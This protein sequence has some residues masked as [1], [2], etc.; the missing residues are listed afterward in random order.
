MTYSGLGGLLAVADRSDAIFVQLAP[1]VS[2]PK[3]GEAADVLGFV[4]TGRYASYLEHSSVLSHS[5]AKLPTAIPV[6]LQQILQGTFDASL[7]RIK[8]KLLS[9]S[10]RLDSDCSDTPNRPA[11]LG[12]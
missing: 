9:Q 10:K 8:G 11:N 2:A 4:G 7:V 1:E 5:P 6:G 3:V 12:G